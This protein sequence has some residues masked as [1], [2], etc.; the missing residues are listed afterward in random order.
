MAKCGSKLRLFGWLASSLR[1]WPLQ[2]KKTAR[3]LRVHLPLRLN[4]TF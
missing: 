2:R 1:S 3:R 4:H